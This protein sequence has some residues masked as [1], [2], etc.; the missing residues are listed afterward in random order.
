MNPGLRR[1]LMTAAAL[2]CASPA[3]AQ[4]TGTITGR[5][6]ER[7]TDRPLVGAQV[8]IVG[9]T[10]GAVTSDSG[11]YRIVNVPAG[12][13]QIAA[14]RLGYGPQSRSVAVA[15]N[16]TVTA[17]FSMTTAVTTLDAL[18]ITATGQ[19]ERR[20]ENGAP[21]ATIDSAS[22]PKAAIS[23][24]S[25][26]LSSRVAGVVVQTSA[27]ETGAGSRIRIRGS[28]SIS[29]SN[30][31]LLIIDGVRADNSTNSSAQATGGQLP[32]R[33]NDI[34]PE[35]IEDVEIIKGPA[36]AALYGTAAA[37]GVIQVTTKKGR[38]GR[39]RWEAFGEGGNLHDV[40]EYPDNLRSYGHTASG[41]LVTNCSLFRR[42]SGVSSACVAIDSVVSNI[43]IKAA[44]IEGNGNRKLVGLST[45]GG[46]DVATYFISGEYHRE[47]NVVAVNAQQQLNLRTNLRAQ[48]TRALDA[49]LNIGYVNSDLRRPQNDNNSF[50][51]VSASLLGRAADCSPTGAKLHPGLCTNGTD[52]VSHGYY[53]QGIDPNAFFNLNTRQQVQRLIG[54]LTSN[55]TPYSWASVNATVGADLNHRNDNETLPPDVLPISQDQLDGY[56]AI[57]KA[58]ISTYTA[59]MNATGTY[60]YDRFKFVSSLGTQYTDNA[61]TRT[62]AFGAKLLAGT[63]S[64]AGTTARFSVGEVNQDVRTLGFLG[65]EEVGFADRV[66]VTAAIRTDRNSA[67]G[68]N[69]RRVYYPSLSASWVLSDEKFFPHISALSSFRLRAAR[70]SAGQNPGFL[71]AQQFFNPVAVTVAGTD[72]PGFTIGGTGNPNLKPEKS[73]EAEGGFDMGLF[74]DRLN[75][76][77]THYS[78]TT[79]DELVNVNLAPSLGSATNRFLNL[80]RVKN[81]GDEAV[82]NAVIVNRSAM[83]LD[84]RMNGSWNSNRLET[85]GLDE[86]GVPI[87]QFTGGFD[88]TQIFKP[89][90]PL[91]AYYVRQ[92]TSVNDANHDGMIACPQ[93]LGSPGCEFTLAD[94]ATYSGSPFPTVELNITPGLDLGHWARITATFDH[95]G[96]QKIYNL[97]GSYRNAI[98]LNGAPVQQ[99]SSSNLFQQAAAQAS[100]LGFNGGYVEDASFTK[101]R[102]VTVAFNLPERFAARAHASSATLTL[103]GRNLHTWTKYS[104][105]DPEVNAGAQ[106]NFT[107]TDFLTAPQIRYLTARLSLGF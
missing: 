73:T 46:S 60:N 70:G 59:D 30:D 97:T 5:V 28:N 18:T 79:R 1:F 26:A 3:F 52:T 2:A 56:R 13:T 91:G 87:P 57:E 48:L 85:L 72:V 8:R 9:T 41:G 36:A 90:L 93:G 40:N 21:T 88:D 92:I 100:T 54:G 84:L 106:A 82:V 50:G 6:T 22:L 11:T 23:T 38:A 27:G 64:L 25:D 10:R 99:P 20:R 86:N 33:F 74:G 45:T 58:I 7:G 32:S 15:G 35:E 98:F 34:N 76:E 103:A 80:G 78:K 61:F 71:A 81:W 67:F 55:W 68:T 83:R 101:L 37:N 69:F 62:D 29:L 19:T 53:N 39:T 63:N 43:P 95:R 4:A 65:R 77:Y 51:V 14:Q 66:F 12:T 49:N 102:E 17:D 42:T 107:T 94:S 44:G 105:V 24:L 96:G 47:Q 31:P 75:L 16:A 89:G 104:G